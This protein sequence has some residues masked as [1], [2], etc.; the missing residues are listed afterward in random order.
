M[1]RFLHHYLLPHEANNHRPK[2]LHHHSLLTL[3]I[4]LLVGTVFFHTIPQNYKAV[5]GIT[6]NISIQELLNLTNEKRQ[7]NGLAPLK[8]DSQL[9]SV[10]E[11]KGAYMF[12]HNFWAHVAPDGTTPWYFFKKDGYD[13]LYA[14]ENLARGFDTATDVVNA[15]MNSPTH[16]ENLLSPNYNDIGF[17]ISTGQL[18]GT[19]TILVVQEFGTR[20][21]AGQQAQQTSSS[22]VNPSPAVTQQPIAPVQQNVTPTN[23]PPEVTQIL[24]QLPKAHSEVAALTNQPLVDSK[25]VT[26]RIGFFILFLLIGVLVIDAIIIEKK[27][28][29]RLVAHNADHIIFLVSIIIAILI[30]GRGFIA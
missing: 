1:K 22:A 8:L 17:A 23:I 14:G 10:A 5:L 6:S 15:W 30:I 12:A 7:D 11:D 29:V 4:F 27:K 26:K 18:T 20:Y 3:I 21:N 2:I 25:S 9:N 28:I 16:R 13:Y 19:D 24:T